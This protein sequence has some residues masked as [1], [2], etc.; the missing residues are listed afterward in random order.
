M[1]R[2]IPASLITEAVA[3]LCV[4]ANR[5]LPGDVCAALQRAAHEEPFAPA[6]DILDIL[7]RNEGIARES[8]MPICQ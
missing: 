4:E 2:E 7:V 3:R 6:R 8:C 5:N 1:M